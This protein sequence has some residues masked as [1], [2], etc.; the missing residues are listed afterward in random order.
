MHARVKVVGDT[1][2]GVIVDPGQLYNG[3]YEFLIMRTNKIPIARRKFF[4]D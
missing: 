1:R 4:K 3:I 2:K